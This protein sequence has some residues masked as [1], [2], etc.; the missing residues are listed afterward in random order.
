[1]HGCTKKG[2]KSALVCFWPYSKQGDLILCYGWYLFSWNYFNILQ[3]LGNSTDLNIIIMLYPAELIKLLSLPPG[4]LYK[5]NLCRVD[6]YLVLYHLFGSA[7]WD[8]VKGKVKSCS[9]RAVPWGQLHFISEPNSTWWQSLT[10][11]LA[12]HQLII[13]SFSHQDGWLSWR[14]EVL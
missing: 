11:P 8:K 1:M 13:W 2:R 9:S 4:I 7:K 10:P 6:S 3:K 5:I 12:C 14:G